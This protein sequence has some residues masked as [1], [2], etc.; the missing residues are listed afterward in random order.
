M[1]LTKQTDPARAAVTAVVARLLRNQGAQ[2]NLVRRGAWSVDRLDLQSAAPGAVVAALAGPRSPLTRQVDAA[3][4]GDVDR[5]LLDAQRK[6]LDS[7]AVVPLSF[8]QS[9]LLVNPA[10]HGLGVDGLGVPRLTNV[11]LKSSS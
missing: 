9:Q 8:G 5:E 10:V 11:W 3:G 2:V 4:P 7:G 1:T 6:L